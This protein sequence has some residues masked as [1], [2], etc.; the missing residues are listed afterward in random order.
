[1][2]RSL[3]RFDLAFNAESLS[4]LA[5]VDRLEVAMVG[6]GRND[7]KRIRLQDVELAYELAFVR[8][9][10]SWEVTLEQIFLRLMCGFNSGMGQAILCNG[11][12]Y[13]P[14]IGQAETLLLNGRQYLLWHNP[15]HV[16]NRAA[17]MF[18]NSHYE[19]VLASAQ[20]RLKHF[21]AVRHR[22]AHAQ[23]DAAAKFDNATMALA[24]KRYRASRPGR[25]LRDR[26]ANSNPPEQWLSMI[27]SEL[28]SLVV[29]LR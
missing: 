10:T 25:F 4:A 14:T 17:G 13:S 9:F 18:L 24:G 21:A 11:L 26:V 29:Q 6:A 28:E 15:D 27:A 1:M 22:V 8:L 20:Q 12:A 23:K 7:P 3:P 16:I 5:L 2:P 19:Q